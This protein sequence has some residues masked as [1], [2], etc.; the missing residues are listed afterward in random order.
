VFSTDDQGNLV[1][2]APLVTSSFA[3][4]T[5]A[6]TVNFTD[7][8]AHGRNAGVSTLVRQRSERDPVARHARLGPGAVRPR[9]GPR[10][11]P[12]FYTTSN[13]DW[14]GPAAQVFGTLQSRQRRHRRRHRPRLGLLVAGSQ[15]PGFYA[16][17]D[18]AF[19]E[20]KGGG[21]NARVFGDFY[22]DG[23]IYGPEGVY[24]QQGDTGPT[25]APGM[26]AQLATL[27]RLVTLVRPVTLARLEHRLHW[28]DWRH[29]S[30]W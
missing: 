8:R 11:E 4:P 16:T 23:N 20:R 24:L 13:P 5:G 2:G 10:L 9:F 6:C 3:A 1:V 30:D 17:A 19:A 22:V 15:G 21:Y 28:S 12:V 25:G 7:G 14:T 26:Q 29:W 18:R 27:V